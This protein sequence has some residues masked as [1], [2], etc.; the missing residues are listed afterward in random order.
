VV[1]KF[2]AAGKTVVIIAHRLGTVMSADRIFVLK[3][4]AL[5]EEGTHAEL[6]AQNGHYV[7]FWK[8]QTEL[9]T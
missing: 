1:E 4:G 3:D 8:S 7:R 9:L 2:K 6:I 5:A